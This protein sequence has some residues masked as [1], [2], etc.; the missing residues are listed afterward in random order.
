MKKTLQCS[1]Q[2]QILKFVQLFYQ[3]VAFLSR[4]MESYC[5]IT[6]KLQHQ[7]TSS[8]LL[9]D[10]GKRELPSFGPLLLQMY[11]PQNV[12]WLDC[13]ILPTK[14][15]GTLALKENTLRLLVRVFDSFAK[16][17][18]LEARWLECW[19]HHIHGQTTNLGE[20]TALY[21]EHAFRQWHLKSRTWKLQIHRTKIAKSAL[22]MSKLHRKCKSI[23]PL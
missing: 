2:S 20:M 6:L 14:P 9:R 13:G 16:S 19:Q 3:P 5:Q 18:E 7:L 21:F 17:W 15:C 22:F 4:G 23:L 1:I 11:L 12:C 8:W 10:R